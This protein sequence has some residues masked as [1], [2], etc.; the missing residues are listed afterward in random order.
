MEGS[1]QS[2]SQLLFAYLAVGRFLSKAYC[3]QLINDNLLKAPNHISI[4]D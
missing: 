3:C 4:T 2:E 1:F